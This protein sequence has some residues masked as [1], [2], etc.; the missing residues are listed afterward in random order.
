MN[1]KILHEFP[2]AEIER[3]WREFLQR[4]ELPSHY[5]APEY[6]LDPLRSGTQPF[7]VLASDGSQVRGV[8]SGFHLDKEVFS[9]LESRPQICIDHVGSDA[10]LDALATGLLK[11][12]PAQ[13]SYTSSRGR[14]WSCLLLRMWD[15]AL[16]N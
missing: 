8:L 6:F 9:G 7:A 16:V 15:S 3:S 5:N 12:L 11:N 4:V 10:T 13:H 1:F 2:P 14:P